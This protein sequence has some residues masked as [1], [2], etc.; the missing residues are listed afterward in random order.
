VIPRDASIE[1]FPGAEHRLSL[2]CVWGH[3]TSARTDHGRF[4]HRG[5]VL[6]SFS[7]AVNLRI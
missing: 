4:H 6:I 1:P 3:R 2:S 7:S 5:L